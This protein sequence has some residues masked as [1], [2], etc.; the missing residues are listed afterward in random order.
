MGHARTES[1]SAGVAPGGS[2][3]PL[4]F[5]APFGMTGE[6]AGTCSFSSDGAFADISNTSSLSS[7]TSVSSALP[8]RTRLRTESGFGMPAS[9]Y[10]PEQL[11][12][13]RLRTESSS[14]HP[15]PA[16]PIAAAAAA[17]AVVAASAPAQV[18]AAAAAAATAAA[19]PGAAA[20][21]AA[22]AEWPQAFL[23]FEAMMTAPSTATG[24]ASGLALQLPL[25]TGPPFAQSPLAPP[26][27]PL[28]PPPPLAAM[29][30]AAPP[31]APHQMA[32]A[33]IAAS[34]G[35]EPCLPGMVPPSTG[36]AVQR[37]PPSVPRLSLQALVGEPSMP[38]AAAVATATQFAQHM[39]LQ[40]QVQMQ[41]ALHAVQQQQQQQHRKPQQQQRRHRR[42]R[43]LQHLI[44]NGASSG[45]L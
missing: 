16:S 4:H 30:L 37:T 10:L 31:L 44:F 20:A 27:A 29:P 43:F 2:Q 42:R 32:A 33:A 45:R 28:A 23:N 1:F 12:H 8:K 21:L 34:T 17:A 25:A 35:L 39:Q 15:L 22:K 13:F 24:V 36:A 41:A 11:A 14:G 9:P 26:P 18:L 38:A 7:G 6:R 40:Q 3:D 19:S 5:A